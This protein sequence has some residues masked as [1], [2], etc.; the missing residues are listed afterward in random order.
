MDPIILAS[1]SPRRRDLLAQ[2]GVSFE[3]VAVDVDEGLRAGEAPEDYVIRLALEKARAGIAAARRA[4]TRLALGADTVVVL[5]GEILL[6]PAGRPEALAMLARLSGRT[7][8][9]LSGVALA[10]RCE[11]ARLSE[12]RVSFRRIEARECE[13]YWETGEPADKAGA[14]AIQGRGAV[15]VDRLEG[16]YSGVVGLP[17]RETA[18]MLTQC[19]MDLYHAWQE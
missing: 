17:L 13:A 7:H 2:I 12:S 19:G 3:V 11:F 15:F 10:G 5:D 6:K 14:Y 8:R 18:E 1:S 4:E 9:V 16:S